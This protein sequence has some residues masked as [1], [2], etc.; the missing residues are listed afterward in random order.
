[1]KSVAALLLLLVIS[2]SVGCSTPQMSS[3]EAFLSRVPDRSHYYKLYEVSPEALRFEG[4]RILRLTKNF[5][6]GVREVVRECRECPALD[7][8]LSRVDHIAERLHEPHL[9]LVQ[10]LEEVYDRKTDT[11]LFFHY[12]VA[13]G[14]DDV[15]HQEWGYLVTRGGIVKKRVVFGGG[16]DD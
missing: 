1:M 15:G 16:T 2:G 5:T 3:R 13:D 14:E 6:Q 4:D 11:I 9:Q 12:W 10:Q 7:A 8:H